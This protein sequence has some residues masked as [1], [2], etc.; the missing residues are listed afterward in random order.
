MY[1]KLEK[2]YFEPDNS[3]YISQMIPE[4]FRF[5]VDAIVSTFGGRPSICAPLV[6]EGKTQGL[7][8]V[9]GRGLSA[10]DIP[11]VEALANHTAVALENAR[12]FAAM[13]ARQVEQAKVEE[14]LRESEQ[15]YREMIRQ[16]TD[17]IVLVNEQGTIIEWNDGIEHITGINKSQALNQHIWDI[18][19]RLYSPLG[20]SKKIRRSV[21]SLIRGILKT[22]Y[23]PLMD[24]P[25]EYEIKRADGVNRYIQ[26]VL[27]SLKT[28]IGYRICS[29]LRDITDWKDMERERSRRTEE[30][31]VLQSL[32]LDLTSVHELPVLL[33]SIVD[34]AVQLLGAQGG[35]LYLCEPENEQVRLY[36]EIHGAPEELIG[37]AIRYGEGCAGLVA[38]TGKPL[39]IDD[40]RVWAGR[41]PIFENSKPYSAVLSAP[42]IWQG[43]VTGV[44]QVL[45]NVAVRK[46]N[47]AD[48]EL[49][50]LFANHAAVALET[51]RLLEAERRQRREAET[52]VKA[53][54][55]LT[56]TLE[57]EQLLDTILTYLEKVVPYDSA[58]IF[59]LKGEQLHIVAGR[60]F[61]NGNTA[62]GAVYP[63][64]QDGLFSQIR[65][66]ARSLILHDAQQDPRF[67]GYGNVGH[68]HGWLG[69]PLVVRSQVIGCLTLDSQQPG[70]YTA[71]HI[72]SRRR[73]PTRQLQQSNTRVYSKSSGWVAGAPKP[74]EKLPRWLARAYP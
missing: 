70:I 57:L 25:H 17:G 6:I 19:L 59:L 9:N 27:Y 21:I 26:V 22:G 3:D 67:H 33:K 73:L 58:S 65:S 39:I 49:L 14:A 53:S 52:L 51:T 62:I 35:G 66:S 2:S 44:L 60:G 30:L 37:M 20:T 29:I 54:S 48:T 18:Q 45:D 15:K 28:D 32:S 16:S 69:V 8:T 47:D 36:V 43:Q 68:V 64:Q 31:A 72:R 50:M 41:S 11:T 7:I 4:E 55:A 71:A 10:E 13:Q 1:W 5:L 63:A 46:F 61:L 38:S 12:L 24:K 40:Y 42:M 23:T 56:S 74:S 34:R